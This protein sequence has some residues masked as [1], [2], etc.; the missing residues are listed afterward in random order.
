VSG[1]ADAS[2]HN[3][4]SRLLREL[5]R[6][7]DLETY[8]FGDADGRQSTEEDQVRRRVDGGDTGRGRT[9]AVTVSIPSSRPPTWK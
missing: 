8:Q 7:G 1:S 4:V 2:Y 9:A 3:D 6:P 5:K